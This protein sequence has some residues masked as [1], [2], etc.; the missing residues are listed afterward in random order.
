LEKRKWD[1]VAEYI[2]KNEPTA[3]FSGEACRQQY[4]TLSRGKAPV[5]PEKQRRLSPKTAGLLAARRKQVAYIKQLEKA[6][7]PK[8]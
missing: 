4:E 2:Q 8:V 6:D 5:P 3:M 1:L 7:R